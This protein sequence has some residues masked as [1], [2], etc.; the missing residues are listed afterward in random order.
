MQ[1][2]EV[3][4][5]KKQGKRKCVKCKNVFDNIVE[6]F[7]IRRYYYNEDKTIKYRTYDTRCKSCVRKFQA[8]QRTIMRQDYKKYIKWATKSFRSRAK[9]TN[10][11]FDLT[12]EY[13]INI[14]EE[15]NEKC[16]YTGENLDFSIVIPAC[17]KRTHPHRL[18]PS[19]DRLNPKKGYIRGNVVWCL[20]Y[21]N[22]M[23]ND[24][25]YD[26][27]IKSCKLILEHHDS[28]LYN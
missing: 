4:E 9:T 2:K 14:F 19:L 20:Y 22:R 10:V 3:L 7:S 5:L 8:E 28:I 23:K 12:D 1:T 27:Y 21:I 18:A 6:N 13:L 17:S 24:L 16:F 15:Q 25:S 11:E 26:E